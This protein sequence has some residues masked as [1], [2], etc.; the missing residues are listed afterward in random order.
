L[1]RGLISG[2]HASRDSPGCRPDRRRAALADLLVTSEAGSNSIGA[3]DR[4]SSVQAVARTLTG[5]IEVIELH[6]SLELDAA[7]TIQKR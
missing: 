6:K 4:P 3:G 5:A 2:R 1:A 7:D